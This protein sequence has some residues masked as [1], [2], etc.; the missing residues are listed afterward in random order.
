MY[1]TKDTILFL[2]GKFIKAV[3]AHTDLYSQTL[4]YGFGAFEGIRAYQSLNGVK[5]FKAF[6]HFER[7]RKSCALV[8]IPFQYE[9][10]ELVQ[11]AYQLLERNNLSDSYIRPLVYCG[12]NM[13]LTQPQ[14]VFLMMCAWEW[15]KYHGDKLLKLCVS[16]YQ[17][18]N[19]NSLKMEAKVTG[20]YVNSILATSEAKVRGYDEALMLDM[21]G[22]VAEAPGAN[23]F[24]E[25][26]GVLYTP[27]VGH[28]LPGITRQTVLNICRE[29][30]I[31]VKERNISPEELESADSAFLCGTAAE[32]AGIESIDAKPF[33]KEWYESLGATVQEA[34]KCQVLEKSFSYVII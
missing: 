14:D 22:N 3:D 13:T 28:I 29:L 25:K 23:F 33:R 7:L 5:I 21:N 30:D 17:R 1:Y 31:P 26:N 19:P 34:Y 2:N 16:S 8:G 4:H 12:P 18:P 10:E 15:D 11:I 27:P 9:T 32:I 20:H 24:L 6:E